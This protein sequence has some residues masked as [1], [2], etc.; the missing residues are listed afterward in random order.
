MDHLPVS[1]AARHDQ[2]HA[3]GDARERLCVRLDPRSRRANVVE[4]LGV[5]QRGGEVELVQAG[6]TEHHQLWTEDLIVRDLV[7]RRES[8]RSCSTC[9]GFGHGAFERHAMSAG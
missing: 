4:V 6:P 1:L 3:I 9:T 7:M 2:A 5:A 8:S